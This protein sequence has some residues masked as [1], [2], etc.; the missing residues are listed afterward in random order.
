MRHAAA[1]GCA[2][3]WCVFAVLTLGA[4]QADPC[5]T[6]ANQLELTQCADR[7][8]AKSDAALNQTYRKLVADLD[9]EHRALLQKAQRAWVAF[10]DA[11]CDL[12]ASVALGGSM[13]PMLVAECRAAMTGARVKELVALRTSLADFMR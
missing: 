13:H 5:K 10:R 2:L 11:D 8:L 9:D 12:D 1:G 6:R 3:A 4:G 7:E